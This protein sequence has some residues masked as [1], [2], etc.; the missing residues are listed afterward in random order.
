MPEGPREPAPGW[1]VPLEPVSDTAE[2]VAK[3]RAAQVK[4]ER[5]WMERRLR[6]A[7]V[8]V[9][10]MLLALAGGL[11]AMLIGNQ[12][13]YANARARSGNLA[14][15]MRGNGVLTATT[16]LVDSPVTGTL[17]ALSVT[18]GQQVTAGQTLA[19]VSAPLLSAALAQAQVAVASAQTSVADAVALQSAAQDEASAANTAAFQQEQAALH[20][21]Q[22]PV[23]TPPPN[24]QDAAIAQYNAVLAHSTAQ[25]AAAQAS[26]DSAQTQ[27]T[28]AN[29]TLQSAQR[30]LAAATLVAPHAGTIAAIT[31]HVGAPVGPGAGGG[32]AGSGPLLTIVDL[33]ALQ[34]RTQVRQGQEGRVR[35]GQVVAFTAA[36]YP[37]RVFR[38]TVS[39]VAPVATATGTGIAFPVMV[40][41][42]MVSEQG[43]SAAMDVP[44]DVTIYLAQRYNAILVPAASVAY[45]HRVLAGTLTARK[46][47][48]GSPDA[49]SATAV[50]QALASANQLATQA[51]ATGA[52]QTA[53]TPTAD[54]LLA[55]GRHGWILKPVLLGLNDGKNVVVLAG[56]KAGDVVTSGQ[57]ALA[58]ASAGSASDSRSA[59]SAGEMPQLFGS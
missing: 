29:G 39:S 41:V 19:Q 15:V 33:A 28:L 24:C 7:A 17:G 57:H 25:L 55:R 45:A 32:Y 50:R 35:A 2:T 37:K 42:D 9:A 14:V 56:L 46:S 27:L 4:A 59:G 8:V 47:G 44:V 22:H 48:A 36:A 40:D 58:V 13:V 26:V 1:L 31:G 10:I 6:L 16:Y 18:V 11:I 12:V 23:G 51:L 38:G 52:G 5:F 30:N 34:V 54:V 43:A 20:A 21:C 49:P 53:D 3:L